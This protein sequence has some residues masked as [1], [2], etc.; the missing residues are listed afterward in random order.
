MNADVRLVGSIG[1]SGVGVVFVHDWVLEDEEVGLV[2]REGVERSVSDF[3]GLARGRREGVDDIVA[4]LAE[5]V[6]L[7]FVV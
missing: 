2:A 1:F 5:V 7:D 6:G 3:F 4:M